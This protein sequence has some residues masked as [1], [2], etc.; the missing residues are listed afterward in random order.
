MRQV[1]KKYRKILIGLLIVV[2]VASTFVFVRQSNANSATQ[3]QTAT[4]ERGNLTTTIGSTGTVRAKQSATLTWQAA[5]S[6]ESVNVQVGDRVGPDDVLAS[7]SKTSLPQS[8][9]TAE[10][11]LASAQKDLDQL[12]NSDTAL[13]QAAID[14]ES[15]QEAYEKAKNYL[16]YLQTSPKVPQTETRFFLQ[17]RRWGWE[18]RTS[19]KSFKAP[20]PEEWI[21]DA[22]NDLALKTSQLEDAQREFDRLNNGNTEDIAAAQARVAAAQATLNLARVI[23][24]F[25]GTVTEAYPLPGDQVSAGADAFRIDDLTSLL[26][27]V[28]VSEVDINSV[29]IGQPVTLSFDA[30]LGKEYHGKVVKV[31]Q[32]GASVSGVVNFKVTVEMIDADDDVKPGM[33]AAV[34]IT[35]MEL[36]DV[37]LVPNRATRFVDGSRVVYLLVDGQPVETKVSLGASSDTMSVLVDGDAKEGDILVLNPSSETQGGPIFGPR[38]QKQVEQVE[39]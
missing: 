8:V 3:F 22:E 36:Q 29:E 20:A 18:Y 10:A 28:E 38:E 6:V 7:L 37:L 13:A 24:P 19:T 9:I 27:D 23:S 33:T 30:V 2:I 34:T 16:T 17:Q 26:V 25:A 1:L 12:L 21:S 5:G 32:T 4:I 11:D 35:I 39:P 31:A 15:A 14:L